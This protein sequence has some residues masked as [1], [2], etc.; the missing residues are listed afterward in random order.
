MQWRCPFDSNQID[1]FK[2]VRPLRSSSSLSSLSPP[3]SLS[4]SGTTAA[5][6]TTTT[7]SLLL[8]LRGYR[9]CCCQMVKKDEI[10]PLALR[11]IAGYCRGRRRGEVVRAETA[12]IIRIR[13]ALNF[14][15]QTAT[16]RLESG[17]WGLTGDFGEGGNG[18]PCIT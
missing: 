5:A 14:D 6:T 7:N 2:S 15:H 18:P 4:L 11:C 8:P 9:Y 12:I 16:C 10:R 17:G 1:H 3:L 13:I